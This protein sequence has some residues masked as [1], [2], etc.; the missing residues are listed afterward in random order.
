MLKMYKQSKCM[1]FFIIY[2]TGRFLLFARTLQQYQTGYLNVLTYTSK[3]DMCPYSLGIFEYIN[4][5]NVA[6]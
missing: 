5:R 6:L 4:I 1:Y 2:L 3:L